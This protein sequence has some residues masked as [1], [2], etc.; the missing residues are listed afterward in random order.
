[1]PRYFFD[2]RDSAGLSLDAEG[3]DLPDLRSAESEA[4]LSLAGMAR[5]A[6][7]RM[8]RQEMGIEVR[9]VNGP[10]FEATLTLD[11]KRRSP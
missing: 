7:A 2:I 5:D 4:S 1:M 8:G 9:S 3:V 10:V 11:V 6:V